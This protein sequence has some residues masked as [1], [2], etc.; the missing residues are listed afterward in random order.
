MRSTA[1]GRFWLGFIAGKKAQPPATTR[2]DYRAYAVR[3]DWDIQS[4]ISFVKAW[5]VRPAEKVSD[6]PVVDPRT[7]GGQVP[8][9]LSTLAVDDQVS[10]YST[11]VEGIGQFNELE[12]RAVYNSR[13]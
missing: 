4:P 11:Y 9:T 12:N 8:P 6:T 3:F 1:D 2:N 13:P 7:A 5:Y 10:V